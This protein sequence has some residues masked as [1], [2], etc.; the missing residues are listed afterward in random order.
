[1]N[2]IFI[3]H[4]GVGERAKKDSAM[5]VIMLKYSRLQWRFKHA[6]FIFILCVK[7]LIIV[8][9]QLADKPDGSQSARTS[10][11]KAICD[12][13]NLTV[14]KNYT[15]D[16]KSHQVVDKSVTKFLLSY[17]SCAEVGLPIWLKESKGSDN[18]VASSK[19]SGRCQNPA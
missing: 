9:R 11:R 15:C 4:G 17:Q 5:M 6:L 14:G 1:M 16:D 10:T 2:R 8:K 3:N 7:P 13:D 19:C 18:L 12:L